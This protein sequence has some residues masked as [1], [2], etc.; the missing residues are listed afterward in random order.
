MAGLSSSS[1]PTVGGGVI[2]TAFLVNYLMSGLRMP[3]PF[4]LIIQL[5]RFD[6]QEIIYQLKKVYTQ[7]FIT[8]GLMKV[9]SQI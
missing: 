9:K 2:G 1:F 8:I 3:F 4:F 7:N 6:P 5:L